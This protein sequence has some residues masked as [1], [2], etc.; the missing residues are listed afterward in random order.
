M[1]FLLLVGDFDSNEMLKTAEKV[2]GAWD[3]E[4]TGFERGRGSGKSARA[5][6][7]ISSTVPGAVQA[8]ILAAARHHAQASG[9]GEAGPHE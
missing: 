7:C 8:Q 4:K 6:A 1:A 5:A 9:L 2:F 3:R